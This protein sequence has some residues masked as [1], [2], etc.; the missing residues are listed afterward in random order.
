MKAAEDPT[1]VRLAALKAYLKKNLPRIPET[2]SPK[3]IY[4]ESRKCYSAVL[5][6]GPLEVGTI[7]G[8][9]EAKVKMHVKTVG[10]ASSA[11][12]LMEEG[13]EVPPE[14]LSDLDDILMPFL[15]GLYGSSVVQQSVFTKLTEKYEGR[16]NDDMSTVNVLPPDKI[17]RVTEYISQIVSNVPGP[18]SPNLIPD[19]SRN[20]RCGNIVTP[21]FVLWLNSSS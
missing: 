20:T 6:G 21:A 10:G 2:T 13:K 9:K 12:D 14:I 19:L 18:S 4:A 3:R 7:P 15:D 17:T 1:G 8:D 5:D 16:F 11:I